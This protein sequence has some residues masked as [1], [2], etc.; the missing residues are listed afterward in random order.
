[1]HHRNRKICPK[2]IY[3]EKKEI[4]KYAKVQFLTNYNIC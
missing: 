1:M 3:T 4:Y 2:K